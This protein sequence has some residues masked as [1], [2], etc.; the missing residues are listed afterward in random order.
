MR[1]LAYG[2]AAI[3]AVGI[4]IAI[5]TTGGPEPTDSPASATSVSA[6]V[7]TMKESGTLTMAVPEMH[8]SFSCFPRVKEALEKNDAVEQ[9]ELGPQ[10]EEGTIDNRQVVVRYKAGFEVDSALKMLAKE[11]F[12]DSQ[13]V[14]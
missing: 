2:I 3:A 10:K 12:T 1:G 9:V 5:A 8:C 6:D 14:Q 4:M 11:G 7:L 13:V